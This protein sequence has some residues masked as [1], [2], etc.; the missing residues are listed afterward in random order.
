MNKTAVML[1]LLAGALFTAQARAQYPS[2][3]NAGPYAGIGLT[4]TF[5]NNAKDFGVFANGF[6]GGGD[7]TATG[8]KVY[9]GY[10]WPNRF[11]VEVG[12]Y[13]LGSYDVKSSGVKTDE[14]AV[15][16]LAVSGVFSMPFASRFDF[17]AKAGL[18]FTNVDYTCFS[19]CTFPYVNTSKSGT[20]GLIGAGVGWRVAPNFIL[21]ADYE[22]FGGVKH[23]VGN[24]EA[25][26]GYGALSV[27]AQVKF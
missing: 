10:L 1:L 8:F 25:D 3:R 26:Y 16:A 7:D 13:D 24:I 19:T 22:W 6:G 17:N 14:F 27:S 15:N 21:R 9:G 2:M 11:G 18:A 20:A 4:S 23:A 5:T 12:Y